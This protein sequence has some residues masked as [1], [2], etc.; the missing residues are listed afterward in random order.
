MNT[1][2]CPYCAD[3]ITVISKDHIFPKFL[4][5]SRTVPCCKKC[6][7]SFG[8][9]FEAAFSATANQLHIMIASWGLSLKKSSPM[10]KSALTIDKKAYNMIIADSKVRLELTRPYFIFDKEN[11]IVSGLFANEKQAQK[12]SETIISKGKARTVEIEYEPSQNLDATK[13]EY[14]FSTDSNMRR[15]AL[16]M[17]MA[18]S[19]NLPGFKSAE[20]ED[21][22]KYLNI[23]NSVDNV[24]TAY[25]AYPEIDA[26]RPGLAHLIFVERTKEYV[27]GIVQF[28]GV[29]QFFCRLGNSDPT[30]EKAALMGRLDP[31]TG[32]EEFSDSRI[33]DIELPPDGH[34]ANE[35]PTLIQGW[36]TKY[37][38]EA[39]ERG[40]THPPDMKITEVSFPDLK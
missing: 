27:Q 26:L 11:Q 7:N 19:V 20:I 1:A 22:R 12:F 34:Y 14:Y 15:T 9:T 32:V 13:I 2:Y 30:N 25:E 6:N 38:N 28:F 35:I 37:R 8:H 36:F 21:A 16:K 17:C 40:A 10:W 5:G 31:L 23:E 33:L 3:E 24:L 4:G 39:I 18:L 29:I